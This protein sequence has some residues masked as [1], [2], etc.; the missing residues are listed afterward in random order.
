MH[1]PFS[2]ATRTGLGGK[3]WTWMV[4]SPRAPRGAPGGETDFRWGEAGEWWRRRGGAAGWVSRQHGPHGARPR[5]AKSADPGAPESHRDRGRSPRD[6]W[7]PPDPRSQGWRCHPPPGRQEGARGAGDQGDREEAAPQDRRQR[8]ARTLPP[9]RRNAATHPP[10]LPWRQRRR[11][12]HPR[13]GGV[14]RSRGAHGAGNAPLFGA[15]GRGEAAGRSDGGTARRRT[16]RTGLQGGVSGGL[17]GR[18]A[19]GSGRYPEPWIPPERPGGGCS[20]QGTLSVF[21]HSTRTF[22]IMPTSSCSRMWQWRG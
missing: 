5:P 3:S 8:E 22:N 12:G 13:G 4:G 17:P 16:R 14:W 10:G 20:W 2:A 1:L 15:G 18:K 6:G 7:S 21:R 9:S 11:T 19:S